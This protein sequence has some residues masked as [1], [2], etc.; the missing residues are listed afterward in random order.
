MIQSLFSLVST[1]LYG[2]PFPEF[3]L[4]SLEGDVVNLSDFKGKAILINFWFTGC[5]PC[6]KEMPALSNIQKKYADQLI[7]LSISFNTKNELDR[8]FQSHTFDFMHLTDARDF[9]DSIGIHGYPKNILINKE[10]V[11]HQILDGIHQQ[12]DKEGTVIEGDGQEIIREIEK[13]LDV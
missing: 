9:I 10:G 1:S 4:K 7:F 12:L 8:F 3:S 5:G 13:V 6:I 2:K 11:V